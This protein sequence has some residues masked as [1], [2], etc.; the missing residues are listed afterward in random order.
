[1]NY[2]LVDD[3]PGF[4]T[5]ADKDWLDHFPPDDSERLPNFKHGSQDPVKELKKRLPAAHAGWLKAGEFCVVT[6]AM[7]GDRAD[8]GANLLNCLQ[9]SQH[10]WSRAVVYS[11]EP[12]LVPELANMPSKDLRAVKRRTSGDPH[13]I[14]KFL[15]TGVLPTLSDLWALWCWLAPMS[16]AIDQALSPARR[17]RTVCAP[18]RGYGMPSVVPAED[19]SVFGAFLLGGSCLMPRLFAWETAA[20]FS[21]E[22]RAEFG[23]YAK[24]AGMRDA[25]SW[26]EELESALGPVRSLNG[27]R[28]GTPLRL[29]WEFIQTGAGSMPLPRWDASW[30]V[31]QACERTWVRDRFDVIQGTLLSLIHI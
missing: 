22:H 17:E 4:W 13:R 2:F 20:H 29:L 28:G 15:E 3:G 9:G 23:I 31:I 26:W 16:L 21:S 18:V 14:R 12:V 19:K 25:E 27:D 24:R 6:D 7:F 10:R 30:R 11:D 5:N 8:G 1:M